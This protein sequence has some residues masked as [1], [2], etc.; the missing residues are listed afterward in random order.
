MFTAMAVAATGT[1]LSRGFWWLLW[2]GDTI[3]GK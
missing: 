3:R 1:L 2:L